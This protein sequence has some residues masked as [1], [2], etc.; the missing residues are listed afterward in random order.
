MSDKIILGT[1]Q[2]GLNYGINNLTGKPSNLQVIEILN[3]ASENRI[4][5]LDTADAYGDAAEII[6]LYNESFPTRF[7]LNTKF[8]KS[9]IPFNRTIKIIS[10]CFKNTSS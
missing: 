5:I 8:T 1:A 3:F 2:F 9:K 10:K 6:G 4:K 7:L